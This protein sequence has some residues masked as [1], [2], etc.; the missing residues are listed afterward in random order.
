MENQFGKVSQLNLVSENLSG[1][2]VLA[3]VFFTAPF[4]IMEPFP[5]DGGLQVMMLSASAGVMAGDRQRFTFRIGENSRMEFVSQSFEKI[6]KMK[7]GWA[8][9]YMDVMVEP[10]ALFD[11]YPQPTIPFAGSAYK[12]RMEINLQDETSRFGLYE[13]LSCGRSASGERFQY[14][15]YHSLIRIRRGGKLIYRDNTRYHPGRMEMEG[16]GMYESYTHLANL[17]L[18]GNRVEKGGAEEKIKDIIEETSDV[19]GGITRLE[20]GD[21]AIRV[22]GRRAQTLQNLT[23]EIKKVVA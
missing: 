21:V 2:T 15:F 19:E 9:R 14:R 13:I 11:F 12:S 20:S 23:E 5:K 16:I 10:N 1:K 7:E 18:T 17:F 8:E 4:K 22:L 3:D 6:H